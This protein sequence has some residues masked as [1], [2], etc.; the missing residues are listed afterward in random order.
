VATGLT[1]IPPMLLLLLLWRT[2]HLGR[3]GAATA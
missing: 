1:A 3:K 2:Q